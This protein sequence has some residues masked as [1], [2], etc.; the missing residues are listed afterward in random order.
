[1]LPYK[2]TYWH[3]GHEIRGCREPRPPLFFSAAPSNFLKEPIDVLVSIHS[4]FKWL[5][6]MQL[7]S[8]DKHLISSPGIV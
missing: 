4:T 2:T 7:V 8:L 6:K 3:T 5:F 1:M